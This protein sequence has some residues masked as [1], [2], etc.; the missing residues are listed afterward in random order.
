M[1]TLVEFFDIQEKEDHITCSHLNDH[2]M[3]DVNFVD[4]AVDGVF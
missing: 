2:E 3:G 1:A 4:T